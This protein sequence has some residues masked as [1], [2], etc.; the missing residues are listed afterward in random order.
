MEK[1][2]TFYIVGRDGRKVTYEIKEMISG[3]A[4]TD[5]SH[6]NQNTDGVRKVTLITCDP[7][8]THKIFSKS[9]TKSRIRIF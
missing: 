7:R 9:R 2:D 4:P 8:R 3:V 5:M 6:T 1:G